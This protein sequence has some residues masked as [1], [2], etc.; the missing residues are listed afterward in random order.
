M[1]VAVHTVVV[2]E[3]GSTAVA[4]VVAEACTQLPAVAADITVAVV[5]GNIT[6]R[7]GPTAAATAPMRRVH[8]A[9][10]GLAARRAREPGLIPVRGQ[11]QMEQETDSLAARQ[12][13]LRA[14][15]SLMVSGMDLGVRRIRR[16]RAILL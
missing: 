13:L 2:A 1:E 11:A 6:L 5:E 4:P 10:Q 8:P 16:G 7:Q 3:A 14:P 12:D 15:Q 9:G